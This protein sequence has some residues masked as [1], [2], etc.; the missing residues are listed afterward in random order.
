MD[1]IFNQRDDNS[2]YYPCIGI[3]LSSLVKTKKIVVDT[4]YRAEKHM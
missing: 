3:P 2:N 1:I 4:F